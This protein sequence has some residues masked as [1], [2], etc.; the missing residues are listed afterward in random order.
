MEFLH[1]NIMHS[2]KAIKTDLASSK[3][4]EHSFELKTKTTTKKSFFCKR[5]N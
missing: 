4:T 2:T 3:I 1:P 5:E